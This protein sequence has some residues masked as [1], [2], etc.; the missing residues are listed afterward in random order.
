MRRTGSLSTEETATNNGHTIMA[1][2]ISV[3]EAELNATS[4]V[5]EWGALVEALEHIRAVTGRDQVAYEYPA[6]LMA[7][8]A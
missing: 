5:N 2:V 8:A 3:L 4:D 7:V 6:R 1:R